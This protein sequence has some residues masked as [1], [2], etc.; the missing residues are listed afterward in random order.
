MMKPLPLLVILLLAEPALAEGQTIVFP[1]PDQA[2]SICPGGMLPPDDFDPLM[3]EWYLRSIGECH[4]PVVGCE[5]RRTT[6]AYGGDR[7]AHYLIHQYEMNEATPG[8][9]GA[10]YLRMIGFARSPVGIQYLLQ[11]IEQPHSPGRD[12][13][14]L[15]G[16]RYSASQQAI[17]KAIEVLGRGD[18]GHL[19][20]SAV[21]VIRANAIL[22]GHLLPSDEAFLRSLETGR[23][24]RIAGSA[25]VALKDLE[26]R[27]IVEQ[28]AAHP[29][30]FDSWRP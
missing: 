22:M 25:S 14:A 8:C 10:H 24:A 20:A 18:K 21:Y 3:K 23:E 5:P 12:Q 7:M 30:E 9:V 15:S 26:Q 17:D 28:K 19:H 6:M 1:R 4:D 2:R 16:L 13:I 11:E 29:V 27:G